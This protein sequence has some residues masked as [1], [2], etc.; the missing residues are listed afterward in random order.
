MKVLVIDN[1]REIG[2]IYKALVP[3]F[4][5]YAVDE[6]QGAMSLIQQKDIDIVIIRYL[7]ADTQGTKLAADIRS[8]FPWLTVFVASDDTSLKVWKDVTAAKALFLPV[9]V[10]ISK[11][12]QV[13]VKVKPRSDIPKKAPESVKVIDEPI[14]TIAPVRQELEIFEKPAKKPQVSHQRK[15]KHSYEPSCKVITVF[16]PKGGVGKTTTVVNLAALTKTYLGLKTAI[17]EFT[18]QTG[19]VLGHFPLNPEIDIGNWV[20]RKELP[21]E[22]EVEDM[23]LW[24]PATELAILPTRKL[25][26]DDIRK[27]EITPEDVEGIIDTLKPHF[28][29]IIIDGGTILDDTLFK[30]LE[31][32][33][34]CIMVSKI[35][36]ETLQDCHYVPMMLERR[37]IDTGKLIHLLNQVKKGL[38]ITPKDALAM[39]GIER[40]HVINFSPDIEKV[41]KEKEPFIVRK[42]GKGRF[43]DELWELASMMIDHPEFEVTPGI[44]SKLKFW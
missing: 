35:E 41:P 37:G 33:D 15:L 5:V 27:V 12:K 2:E 16:S 19:N 8:L 43:Y 29:C 40:N 25:I 18:R 32:S 31:V 6:G 28:D 26:D 38:G 22:D 39:V 1:H 44:W 10:D 23:L 21:A 30:I 7:L 14:Q 9:P 24:C 13:A 4:E 20:F 17:V 42:K 3:H 34:H 36:R 11:I